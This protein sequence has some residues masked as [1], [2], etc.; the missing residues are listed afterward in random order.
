M[1][2]YF[3]YLS[4]VFGLWLA[5]GAA[6]A[7]A[8]TPPPG[9]NPIIRNKYTADPAALVQGGTVYLYT[10]H[11]EAPAPQERYVMHDWLCFSSTDMVTWTEHPVPLKVSDFAWAKDDAWASQVIARNG[12]FYW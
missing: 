1:R 6:W 12:K 8:P 2:I 11:D 7:Q 4:S 10:G 5:V 9:G 3:T